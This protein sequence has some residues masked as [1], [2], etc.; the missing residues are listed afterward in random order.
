[1]SVLG[2]I[3]SATLGSVLGAVVLYVLGRA[4]SKGQLERLFESRIGKILRLKKADADKTGNWFSKYGYK[5][6]FLC[7]FIPVIRSLISIPAGMAKMNMKKFLLLTTL[8]TLIW[9]TVL[10][11]LGRLAGEAWEKVIYYFDFYTGISMVVMVVAIL[12]LAVLFIRNRFF[13]KA[14]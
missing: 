1:L 5:A 2:V 13:Q 7:R 6:V 11:S 3:I 14:D 12:L 10:V 9:N 8:G 4:L